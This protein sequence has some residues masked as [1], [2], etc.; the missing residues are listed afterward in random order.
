MAE[1]SSDSSK[2]GAD[3]TGSAVTEVKHER[4]PEQ[5][6]EDDLA[7]LRGEACAMLYWPSKLRPRLPQLVKG[8]RIGPAIA[9]EIVTMS[10]WMFRALFRAVECKP[11]LMTDAN[12]V[13]IRHVQ[14]RLLNHHTT[15]TAETVWSDDLAFFFVR[16]VDFVVA[17]TASFIRT[18]FERERLKKLASESKPASC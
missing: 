5:Q 2:P 14:K 8:R 17:E 12:K 7:N 1:Q 16:D 4:E 18:T 3:A 10:S 6:E 9:E 13:L 11:G 15:T